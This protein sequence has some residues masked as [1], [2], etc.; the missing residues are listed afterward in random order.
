[1]RRSHLFIITALAA[2]V[3]SILI[4][5]RSAQAGEVTHSGFDCWM[6]DDYVDLVGVLPTD[7]FFT[8]DS[9]QSSSAS[10]N[11]KLVCRFEGVVEDLAQAYT[12]MRFMCG[13]FA[14]SSTNSA[15]VTTQSK[16]VLKPN[17]DILFFCRL[18]HKDLPPPTTAPTNS[19]LA[20]ADGVT[21]IGTNPGPG[22]P[23]VNPTG[24]EDT[25]TLS[26]G[27]ASPASD[28]AA[29]GD[30]LTSAAGDTATID[31]PPPTAPAEGDQGGNCGNNNGNGKG[32]SNGCGNGKN[33]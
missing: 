9:S 8:T 14:G 18:N 20:T 27:G 17:G 4:P 24:G 12:R 31:T 13:V 33:P 10:G 29:A 30:T 15:V 2:I 16:L 32:A 11:I 21:T 3:I 25:T 7:P 6:Y 5:L 22:M 19:A 26:D 28:G 23:G 1:M